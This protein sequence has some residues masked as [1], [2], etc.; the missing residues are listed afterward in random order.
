[1]SE[2]L[3]TDKSFDDDCDLD[4]LDCTHCLGSGMQDN[5][6]P[7]WHGFDV[8]EIPCAACRGTGQRKHQWIW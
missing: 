3:P 1:M 8:D 4:D 7:A 5:D 2:P 6:D